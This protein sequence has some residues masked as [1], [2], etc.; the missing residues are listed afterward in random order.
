[1]LAL[2]KRAVTYQAL[3]SKRLAEA[4]PSTLVMRLARPVTVRAWM[5][6]FSNQFVLASP[7]PCHWVK[8]AA[9][10]RARKL[11]QGAQ[12]P[13]PYPQSCF[14]VITSIEVIVSLLP[15]GDCVR[16]VV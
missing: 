12:L 9:P 6:E 10:L 15:G 13:G 5:V 7:P 3:A 11:C 8:V 16:A 4:T 2:V 14:Q 1:M